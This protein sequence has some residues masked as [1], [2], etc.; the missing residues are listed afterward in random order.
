MSTGVAEV[1]PTPTL[2]AG[3]AALVLSAACW[4]VAAARMFLGEG[5]VAMQW[6]G[7]AVIL[8]AVV[9]ISRRTAAG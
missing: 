3:V 6:I 5:L 9:T 7:G 8:A 2:A 1:R 4:G